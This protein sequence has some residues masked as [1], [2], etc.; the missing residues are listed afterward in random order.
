MQFDVGDGFTLETA[1]DREY[2]RFWEE[3][4]YSW[5]PKGGKGKKSGSKKGSSK[6]GSA[7]GGDERRRRLESIVQ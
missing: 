7:K 4:D 2:C 1:Q 5:M 6:K 3:F